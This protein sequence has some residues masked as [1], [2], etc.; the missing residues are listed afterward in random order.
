MKIEKN[1]RVKLAYTL[2]YDHANGEEIENVSAE[3]PLEITIGTEDL[4]EKFEE[5]IM[6]LKKGDTFEFILS[7]EEAYG[8]YDEEGIVSVPKSELMEDVNGVEIFEGEIIP[9]VTDDNDEEMEAVVLEIDGDIVTLD[10]N[11][12][13][14]GE[15]LYFS[16][17]IISIEN[18]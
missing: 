4:L 6:G 1:N 9:I 7:P 5:K 17:K 2:K 18:K 15:T 11:H 8:N 13:L 12:P 16:G 10:F 3:K 14:A